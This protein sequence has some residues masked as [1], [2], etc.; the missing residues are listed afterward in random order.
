M[1]HTNKTNQI[2]GLSL[3]HVKQ[4]VQKQFK[5]LMMFNEIIQK[6]KINIIFIFT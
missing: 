2:N 6:I 3:K 5:I 4:I 1:Y